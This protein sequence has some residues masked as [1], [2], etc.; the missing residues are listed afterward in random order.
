MS[1]EVCSA[2]AL[3]AAGGCVF[4]RSPLPRGVEETDGLLDYLAQRVP[5]ATAKRGLFGRGGVRELRVEAAGQRFRARTRKDGL[6]LEPE[7]EP[8]EWADRLLAAL[9]RRAASD[10]DVRDAVSRSGWALR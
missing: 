4:C 2:P 5:D 8:A 7:L 3:E 6:R 1:C 10:G 9:S